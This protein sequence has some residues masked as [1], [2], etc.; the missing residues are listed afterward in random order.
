M[1]KIRYKIIL[2]VL[3]LLFKNND[4]FSQTNINILNNDTIKEVVN[5]LNSDSTSNKSEDNFCGCESV[6]KV[7]NCA[8]C[9]EKSG[10]ILK[11]GY[12]MSYVTK[13]IVRGSCWGFVNAV[14]NKSGVTKE[15]IFSSKKG[16][17]FA[18]INDL[19]PG[20]WIYHVNY[21]YGM[22]EHSAIFVCW[23]DKSQKQAITLSYAGQNKSVPGRLSQTDLKGV[24]SI[25]RAK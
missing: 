12:E 23:K 6:E 18:K 17:P 1:K 22:V 9:F 7:K 13:T 14:Y 15:T 21:S 20:D 25:F 2:F 4:I 8:S 11:I 3:L 19:K 10:P 16:G 24:Y 5:S